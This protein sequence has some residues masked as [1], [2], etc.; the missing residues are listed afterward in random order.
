MNAF[1][2]TT[3]A[4]NQLEKLTLTTSA[5]MLARVRA[6]TCAAARS[7]GGTDAS[8][9]ASC[10]REESWAIALR[11]GARRA[12]S[13]EVPF[14]E[15]PCSTYSLSWLPQCSPNANGCEDKG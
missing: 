15:V 2:C 6:V 7:A 3:H 12:A 11:C 13:A 14:G 8:G 9:G 1:G 4:T 10:G 5:H